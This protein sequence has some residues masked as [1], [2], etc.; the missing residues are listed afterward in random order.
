MLR[1]VPQVLLL[2]AVIFIIIFFIIIIYDSVQKFAEASHLCE[3]KRELKGIMLLG[4]AQGF[5]QHRHSAVNCEVIYRA[6]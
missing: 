5:V 3:H 2:L 6:N 1:S 4:R